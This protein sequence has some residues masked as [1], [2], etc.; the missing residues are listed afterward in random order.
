MNENTSHG[1]HFR[2]ETFIFL[3]LAATIG[4]AIWFGWTKIMSG[5]E[6]NKHTSQ[7]VQ[8]MMIQGN[9]RTSLLKVVGDKFK[10][11]P[12]EQQARLT[13]MIY[14]VATVRNVPLNLV[15]AVG[16]HESHFGIKCISSANA[17]GWMQILPATARPYIRE[18][19]MNYSEEALFDPVV[20]AIVG[21]NLLAD[22]HEGHMEAGKE[23]PD[24]WTFTL[25]SYLW[26]QTATEELY[27]K[28]DQRVNVPNLHYPNEIND[29]RKKYQDM[30][31]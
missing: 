26:S 25:H 23:K 24:D 4:T 9:A 30:G 13:E 31:L 10:T 12:V 27:G 18:Q 22:I 21:I 7:L 19:R 28:R 6:E 3:L 20:C 14:T 11:L 5:I 1:V 16:E 29:L 8:Q 17:K 15:M 2:L